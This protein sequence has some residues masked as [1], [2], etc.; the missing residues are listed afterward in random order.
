MHVKSGFALA[1]M[2]VLAAALIWSLPTHFPNVQGKYKKRKKKNKQ[3][4]KQKN[5]SLFS[6]C[7]SLVWIYQELSVFPGIRILQKRAQYYC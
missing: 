1:V 4:K 7:G 2:Q 5:F 3:K 6:S